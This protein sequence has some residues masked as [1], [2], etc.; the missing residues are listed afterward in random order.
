MRGL[1]GGGC[2]GVDG[3]NFVG[4][5]Y[6]KSCAIRTDFFNQSLLEGVFDRLRPPRISNNNLKLNQIVCPP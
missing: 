4:V 3:F 6:F 5:F 1:G 2:D